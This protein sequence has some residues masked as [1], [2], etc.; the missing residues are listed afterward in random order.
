M[1]KDQSFLLV[2]KDPEIKWGWWFTWIHI[3]Y[4]GTFFVL[5]FPRLFGL[6]FHS[7]IWFLKNPICIW[8]C[9]KFSVTKLVHLFSC[10]CC[11]SERL[12]HLHQGCFSTHPNPGLSSPLS[13][14]QQCC[15]LTN[16]HYTPPLHLH[17]HHRAELWH[18]HTH[19]QMCSDNKSKRMHTQ[20]HT[21]MGWVTEVYN[22]DSIQPYTQFIG[23]LSFLKNW[24]WCSISFE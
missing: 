22:H 16:R 13:P 15:M 24:I 2:G 3:I 9:W 19:T 21:I 11:Y 14:Q 1:V 18:T 4:W 17:K 5:E 20:T 10:F 12:A 7:P 23:F 6:A 8:T